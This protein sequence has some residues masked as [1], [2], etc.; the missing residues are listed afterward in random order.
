[1]VHLSGVN[2]AFDRVV[3]PALDCRIKG[4]EFPNHSKKDS[5]RKNSETLTRSPWTLIFDNSACRV[6]SNRA[7]AVVVTLI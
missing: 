2:L 3:I 6:E 7:N 1:M 4:N 5:C